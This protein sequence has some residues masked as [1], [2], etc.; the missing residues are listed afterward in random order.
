MNKGLMIVVDGGNGAGKGTC[1][2]DIETY[3]NDLELEVV[4]T[5][6]PGGTA[7]GEKIREILLD[8]S[9]G[10]MCDVTELLLFA[11]ARAQH[12]RQKIIP[13]IN[14]GKV[15]VSDR[16]DSATVS[17]QHYARGLDLDLIK[18]LND[19][20]VA[21]LRPDFTIILD[22]DP[23]LGLQRVASRGSDF[24]RLEKENLS[25]LERARQGY[26]DQAQADP[27]H[28]A[29]VDASQSFEQVRHE[30]L[31]LVEQVISRHKQVSHE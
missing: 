6:E 10:E 1:L 23:A 31:Q 25:F 27:Q 3:L 20:A 24:D 28:F 8:K 21:G 12:V 7:I 17:F 29:T 15:V 18:Q 26:I 14:A 9:A 30:V 4:M 19:I 2:R 16:F 13:A 22:L 5:R 11:A